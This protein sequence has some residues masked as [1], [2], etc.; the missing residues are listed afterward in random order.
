MIRVCVSVRALLI[1]YMHICIVFKFTALG[2]IGGVC[3]CVFISVCG[4]LHV[5][6]LYFYWVDN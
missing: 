6:P 2:C 5:A 4:E 3:V 1:Q